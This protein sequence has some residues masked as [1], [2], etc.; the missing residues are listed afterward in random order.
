LFGFTTAIHEEKRKKVICQ[1]LEEPS[2]GGGGDWV[3]KIR[4]QE[5][6]TMK[7]RVRKNSRRFPNLLGP[8][9]QPT[10][11][12]RGGQQPTWWGRKKGLLEKDR[13]I[14]ALL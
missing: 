11:L 3:E 13:K 14:E 8:V 5:L 2:Q 4:F 7:I 9:K 6:T 12:G 1:D 10:N